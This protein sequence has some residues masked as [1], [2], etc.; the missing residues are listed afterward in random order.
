M[1]ILPRNRGMKY[2]EFVIGCELVEG[3]LTVPVGPGIPEL[4]ERLQVMVTG[5][6]SCCVWMSALD[7]PLLAACSAAGNGY[8]GGTLNPLAAFADLVSGSLA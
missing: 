4:L 5:T 1:V 3:A 2:L 6:G 8:I 7:L